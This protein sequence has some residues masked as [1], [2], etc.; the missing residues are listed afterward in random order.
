MMGEEKMNAQQA[1]A[2]RCMLLTPASNR[3]MIEK[4]A[5][6]DADMI[7]LDL[8]D[9]VV[10]E[11]DSKR[12]ARETLV[13]AMASVDFRGKE[14]AVRVNATD[15]PWWKDDI[16]ACAEAGVQII[17]PPKAQTAEDLL[18]VTRLIDAL[19]NGDALRMWP[20]I[21]T[22]GAIIH[23]EEIAST[24]PRLTGMCFGIGDYTVSVGSHFVDTPDRV[25]YP[26]SKLACVA[27]YHGLVPLA[28]AVAFS[29]MGRDAIIEEWGAFLKRLGFDGALVV[30][31]KHVAIINGIFSPSREEIDAALEMREAIAEARAA[32][33]AAIIIGGR[34]IEKVNIDI[35]AR[36][37]AIAE[38]LG[39]IDPLEQ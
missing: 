1:R 35:A 17:M 37:L 21:E 2:R 12:G 15:T 36:T 18:T 11:D 32:N 3:G 8:D 5:A 31:P 29:N 38:R 22:T 25:V 39:L 23:C 10:Y 27:R 13:Q 6:S 9:A 33:R 14:V 26:L 24:V 7:M 30:H 19:P 16:R 4:A 28:P 34:L 20:M